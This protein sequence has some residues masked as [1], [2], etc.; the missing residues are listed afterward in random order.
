MDCI[1]IE[2]GGSDNMDFSW[3]TFLFSEGRMNEE[4]YVVEMSIPFKSIRF[5]DTEDKVWGLTLGRNIPR[6]GEIL[7]W[8][9]FTREISG[10]ISQSGEI[11]IQ[12]E[13]EKGK[14]FEVM[15]V[16]T[17]LKTI[18]DIEGIRRWDSIRL[19]IS[20]ELTRC[21]LNE[22]IKKYKKQNNIKINENLI[23]GLQQHLFS[24]SV[25]IPFL[26]A[27]VNKLPNTVMMR[28]H[29]DALAD[30]IKASTVLHQYQRQ[31]DEEGNIVEADI[32]YDQFQW[33]VELDTA[34]FEPNIPSNYQSMELPV[35]N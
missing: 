4:G 33:D 10:L 30:Y 35:M 2:E 3:D 11:R 7:V 21:I 29:I 6:K 22:K 27:L 26:D 19:D 28:T 8:P 18:I 15:P 20:E 12:G 25:S 14:N 32:I 23:K 16:V 31:K 34:M 13:V 1:R 9:E 24:K 5:P 17:S